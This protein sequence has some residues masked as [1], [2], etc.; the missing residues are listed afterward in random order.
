MT[1]TAAVSVSLRWIPLFSL[2]RGPLPLT[3]PCRCPCPPVPLA[4]PCGQPSAAPQ[5]WPCWRPGPV[6][7]QVWGKRSG[8]GVNEAHLLQVTVLG[9][10][11]TYLCTQREGHLLSQE[12][13]GGPSGLGKSPGRPHPQGCRDAAADDVR[14][15]RALR[16]G[17]SVK[18]TC[19][20]PCL[21]SWRPGRSV[22]S[23]KGPCAD[24][25]LGH[26]GVTREQPLGVTRATCL[27]SFR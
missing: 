23:R 16:T 1:P 12:D 18:M 20:S 7:P 21:P 11:N 2:C 6:H 22:T 13:R 26:W 19:L 8:G 3:L 27:S 4:S 10:S 15:L 24:H 9:P 14:E 5:A 25:L 17:W